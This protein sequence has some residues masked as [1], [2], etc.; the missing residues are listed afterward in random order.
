VVRNYYKTLLAIGD[1]VLISCGQFATPYRGRDARLEALDAQDESVRK[2]NLM[3][4]Y[5]DALRFKFSP[6]EFND[7]VIDEPELVAEAQLWVDVRLDPEERRT[8][9]HWTGPKAYADDSFI[10]E[11]EMNTL[12]ELPKNVLRNLRCKQMSLRHPREGLY[13]EITRLLL[14][15]SDGWDVR[16]AAALKIWERYN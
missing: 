14:N 1:A 10:R 9:K 5:R 15:R 3:E 13:R 8:G 2:L 6:H 16:S 7:A 12:R 11:P 4:R